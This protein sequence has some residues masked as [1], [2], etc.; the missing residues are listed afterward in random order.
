MAAWACYL[1][2][3]KDE[4]LFTYVGA[5]TDVNRRLR[6]HN[7]EL[8]GG[9]RKTT[10]IAKHRG[11]AAWKRVCHVHGFTDKI[12][13]L[14]FEWFWKHV[15][16]KEKMGNPYERRIHALQKLLSLEE[17]ENVIVEWE[18]NNCPAL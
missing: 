1:L 18:D 11:C 12:Q 16:R 9:A 17:W 13:A 8:A 10:S 6:Q 4:P 7:C 2:I 14:R 15:S 3:T 5:S